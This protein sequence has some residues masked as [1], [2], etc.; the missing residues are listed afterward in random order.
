MAEGRPGR[1]PT[2]ESSGPTA[3]TTDGPSESSP[4]RALRALRALTSGPLGTTFFASAAIQ[5]LYVV[6]GIVLA[7]ALG[8]QAR[9]E[10]AAILLWTMLVASVGL[11]GLPEAVTYETAR[12][13]A[14][15]RMV[16]G[17]AT[18]AGIVL[19][20]ALLGV[21]ALVLTATLGRYDPS[22]RTTGYV[23]LA[24]IPL[25]VGASIA[26]SALQGLRALG[27]F[28]AARS[29]VPITIA[30]LL[31]G[32]A[33][34]GTLT[35]RT[36]IYAYI[37]TYLVTLVFSVYLLRSRR[38]W[39][40]DFDRST[41]RRLLG[42][43][44]RGYTTFVT[45]T[46][47][48][49]LGMLLISVFLGATSLGLYVVAVTLGSGATFAASTVGLVAFPQLA[50]LPPGPERSAAARRFVVIA[51]ALSTA[52]T[53]PMLAFTPQLLDLLFGHAFASVANVS[54]VLI[55]ASFF[56]AFGQLLTSVL[57][58][59]GRPL[60]SG[61]AGTV[62]LAVT[63]VLLTALLPTLGL[64]GAAITGLV[65]SIVTAG[66]MLRRVLR[67]LDVSAT[68]LLGL[69]RPTRVPEAR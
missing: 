33:A 47:T 2:V 53:V 41:L 12:D 66:M 62:G 28:N 13:R 14:R 26:T 7:R 23:F 59:L 21:G 15:A 38:L 43:G 54:R 39:S 49:L 63:V 31:V 29:A 20:L 24:V 65:A 67:A 36:A 61:I 51:L 37:A 9:G 8:P 56:V 19:S 60:D 34:A 3:Q 11:I 55:A 22:I 32:L 48:S 10:V 69:G 35:V 40:F 30:I 16:V 64:M 50:G 52:I 58:G 42:Y 18:R 27:A 57:R 1:A 46:L 68:Y 17:T 6:T 4:P 25:Y 45:F 44:G 5:A